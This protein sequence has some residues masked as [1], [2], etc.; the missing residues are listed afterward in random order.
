MRPLLAALIFALALMTGCATTGGQD[1]AARIGVQYATPKIIDGDAARAQSVVDVTSQAISLAAGGV[2]DLDVLEAQVREA[3]PWDDM[4]LADRQLVELLLLQ[5][6]AELDQRV[7]EGLV[8]ADRVASSV[9]VLQ[10]VHDAAELAAA[11]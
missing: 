1:V 6:R 4:D 7:D 11:Q 2:V 9:E 8:E 3:I 5:V 10:W